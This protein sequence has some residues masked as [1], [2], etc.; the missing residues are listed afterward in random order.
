MAG[1]K[2][3]QALTKGGQ[4]LLKKYVYLAAEVARRKDPELAAT[5]ERAIARGKHHYSAVIIV[6]H[7]LVRRVYALLK[8]RAAGAPEIRYEM[9]GPNGRVLNADEARACIAEHF[10]SKAVKHARK[11]ALQTER[12]TG[13]VSQGSGSSEDATKAVV[14][15]V[16][17]NLVPDLDHPRNIL[18]LDN[19]SPQVKNLLDRS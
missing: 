14:A 8:L 19:P 7:K 18:Q 9:R 3:R 10:P 16:P 11:R 12:Q 6:A 1:E 5:Y 15:A 13:T 4:N 2:P 17:K